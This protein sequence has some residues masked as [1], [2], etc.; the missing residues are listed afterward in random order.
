MANQPARAALKFSQTFGQWLVG[1]HMLAFVP[2]IALGAFW[3]AGELALVS[4]ALGLPLLFL[5]SGSI[6]NMSHSHMGGLDPVTGLA[7]QAALDLETSKLLT[8]CAEQ[9]RKTALVL[10]QLEEFEPLVQRYGQTAANTLLERLAQRLKTTLRDNDQVFWLGGARYAILLSPVPHF[11][12]ESA[13]QL[14]S[15]LQS[16]IEEPVSIETNTLY[17]SCAIGFCLSARSPSPSAQA[18]FKAAETALNEAARNA[19]S[20]IRSFSREMGETSVK[21][22]ALVKDAHASLDNGE[23]EP[24]FQ[25]QVST[26]TGRITGFEALARWQHPKRGTVSPADFLPALEESGQMERLGEV[27]LYGA[28]TALKAWDKSGANVPCVAVNF[29]AEELRNPKLS[30]RIRWDLDRFD[31]EPKRL[32]IEVL[33]SIVA[34]SPEDAAARNLA[35]LA[36][37]GCRIDLDDFGTGH[38][39]ITAIRRL[40]IERIKIDRSFVTRVDKDQ[41]QQ[42]MVSAIQTMAERLGLETLAEG[43]ETAGEHAMLGQLG[44]AHVQ[45]YG[46]AR[47]M[48]FE[49][50]ISWLQAHNAA[51]GSLPKISGQ[52]R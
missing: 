47:P 31:L 32:T 49:A 39:S 24:W 5:L 20:A 48:P 23:I 16:A 44:C 9:S 37:M 30:E 25:P 52:S 11:E 3:F 18:L 38:A 17:V 1:P 41:E 43:V 42:R 50:T 46:I 19:P 13:I 45:G 28:L 33:E 36:E 2:A 10:V 12:L 26:D 35:K 15:R 40:A 6:K 34:G 21:R 7:Q 22:A 8:R 14:T 4:V 51:L 27:I 29:T